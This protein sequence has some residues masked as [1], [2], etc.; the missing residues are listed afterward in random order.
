MP[1]LVDFWAS[2]CGPCRVMAPELEKIAGSHAGRLLVGK[3]DTDRFPELA[4]RYS[5]EALPTL[6]FFR[7]GEVQQ[8]L[9]GARP[10]AT[11]VRELSL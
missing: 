1:L 9:S 4:Q 6:V 2:W 10:A 8:R 5:I 11:I 7:Q 3:V